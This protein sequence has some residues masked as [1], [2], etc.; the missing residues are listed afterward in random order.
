[1]TWKERPQPQPASTCGLRNSKPRP[2][3]PPS[4]SSTVP[5]SSGA[6]NGS[7]TTVRPVELEHEVVVAALVVLEQVLEARAAAALDADA[8][9]GVGGAALGL[10]QGDR[11]DAGLS[12]TVTTSICSSLSARGPVSYS[13]STSA[14]PAAIVAPT[15]EEAATIGDRPGGRAGR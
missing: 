11:L 7:I 6:E 1:M 3:R 14:C 10:A 8:Q 15:V 2:P 5:A 13:R 4:Y 9:H 12:L